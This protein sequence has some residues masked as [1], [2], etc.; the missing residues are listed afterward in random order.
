MNRGEEGIGGGALADCRISNFTVCI[1]MLIGLTGMYCA[2]KNH[3][4]AL[5]ER[6]GFAVLD[7]D[8]LGYIAIENK[9]ADIFTRFGKNI[10]NQDGSV[11]RR[12]LGEKVFGRKHELSALEAIV[13]PEAN[14]LTLEWIAAHNG[15]NC[16]INA[17][18][19]HKSIIFAQLQSIIVVKSSLSIRLI[20]AKRRDKLPWIGIFRRFLSQKQF[21]AQYLAE[22]AD[23]YKVENSGIGKSRLERRIDAILSKLGAN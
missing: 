21:S 20:R 1:I 7:V 6:R 2:G 12:Q 16:V 10:Q 15:K 14:R 22:N 23:I 18:L 9:K 4:A 5:L 13:H 11:N 3:V 17:A 8:K 19:L